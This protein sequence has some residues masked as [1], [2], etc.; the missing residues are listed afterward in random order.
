L[1]GLDAENARAW[2]VFQ[3]V[4]RRLVMDWQLAPLVLEWAMADVPETDRLDVLA[5]LAVIYDAMAPPPP[6]TD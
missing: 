2:R 6:K 3:Q 5:R 4:A 1:E